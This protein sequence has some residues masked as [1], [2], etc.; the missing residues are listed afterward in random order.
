M[1]DIEQGDEV[2]I[3]NFE[4][5]KLTVT[6]FDKEN[7]NCIYLDGNS[8]FKTVQ[9]KIELLVY[10]NSIPVTVPKGRL[11]RKNR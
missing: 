2:Y 11:P 4:N 3:R 9:V 1:K 6:S 7:V 8:E 5:K 10:K